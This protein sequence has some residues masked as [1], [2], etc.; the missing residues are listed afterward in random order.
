MPIPDF[1]S[2]MLPLLRLTE[3]KQEHS[4]REA[5]E[6][7]SREFDITEEEKKVLQPSGKQAIIENRVSWARIYLIKAGLLESSRRSFFRITDRGSKVLL[8]N[9][10]RIDKRYLE[11]L[12][13]YV[14]FKTSGK[15]KGNLPHLEQ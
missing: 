1:Q 8:T 3:D 4:F 14:K 7:I 2:I 5:V 12:P 9:P 10:K 11:R 15:R 6:H 13:G